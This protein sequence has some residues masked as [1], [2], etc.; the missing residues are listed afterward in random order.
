MM[1]GKCE[2]C[3]GTGKEICDNPDHGFIDAMGFH[4][5]GRI[6]CPLCGHDENCAIP[7]TICPDCN[8]TGESE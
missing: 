6:G 8:G 2:T 1:M 3:N 4:D 5:I 7:N